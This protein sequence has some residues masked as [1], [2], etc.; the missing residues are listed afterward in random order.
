MP[1][2][3]ISSQ[4][5]FLFLECLYWC[6]IFRP[7]GYFPGN[8]CPMFIAVLEQSQ[9]LID[10]CQPS[11]HQCKALGTNESV[12]GFGNPWICSIKRPCLDFG[13]VSRVDSL[14]NRYIQ[15]SQLSMWGTYF[16]MGAYKCKRDVVAEINMGAYIYGVLILCGCLLSQFYDKATC[17]V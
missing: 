15:K 16:C 10:R 8:F 7:R 6:D 13:F 12:R 3:K 1:I 14:L 5:G 4:N 9:Q 2:F 11:T 17:I